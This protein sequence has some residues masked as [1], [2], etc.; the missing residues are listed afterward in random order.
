M[1]FPPAF[2]DE[3]RD[4]I[5]ISEV[6]GGKVKLVRRG[7]EHT[8]LCP[9]HSERTPS[10]TVNDDKGFYHCFGCGAHGDAIAFLVEAEG[11]S[12][13]DAVER[14]AAR[15]GLPLPTPDPE[16]AQRAER[17]ATL[18]DANELAVKWFSAQLH[19]QAGKEALAYLKRRGLSDDTIRAFRLGFAPP[20]RTGLA[21]A[22]A[23]RGVPP[24]LAVE[25]GLLIQPED[26]GAP[27]DRFRNR[28][29]FPIL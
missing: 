25:A 26:G 22:L 14:L 11:L 21:E 23:A 4:R 10:F 18:I 19:A 24:A 15:A 13:R 29:M 16:A 17:R 3:L 6:V 20:G 27:F 8:G 28:V 1:S 5:R 12:F 2:L 7:R 9:F